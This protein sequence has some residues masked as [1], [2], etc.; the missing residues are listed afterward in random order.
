MPADILRRMLRLAGPYWHSERKW[1]VRGMT[2]L[3]LLLTVAQVGLTVW[4]N[5][6]NRALFDALEQRSIPGVLL[7]V[8]IFALILLVSSAFLSFTGWAARRSLSKYTLGAR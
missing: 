4:G 8:G 3:L 2:L 7:Q 1:Q 6:W 5:Y